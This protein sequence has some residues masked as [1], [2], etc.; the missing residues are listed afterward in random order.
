[1]GSWPIELRLS[2]YPGLN[3]FRRKQ[4]VLQHLPA[5]ADY[6]GLARNFV[7]CDSRQQKLMTNALLGLVNRNHFSQET[8]PSG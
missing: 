1:M 3:L 7:G 8:P 6:T 4:P 5:K 2:I